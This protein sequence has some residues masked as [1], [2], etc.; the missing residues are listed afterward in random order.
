MVDLSEKNIA[1]GSLALC[2]LSLSV[3]FMSSN[4][5]GSILTIVFLVLAV[6][7]ALLAYAAFQAGYLVMPYITKFL[8]VT[9][10]V[11]GEY[12]I[13]PSQDVVVRNVG[14]LYQASVYLVAK[15]HE[16]ASVGGGEMESTAYM[17]LWERSLSTLKFPMAY[18]MIVFLEDI[19]KYREQVETERASAQIKLG[20][21]REKPRPDALVIDKWER[22]LAKQDEKLAKL[23]SGEKPMG[24]L[25]YVVTTGVGVNDAAAIAAAKKQANEIRSTVANALNV[26]IRSTSGEDLRKCFYFDHFLPPD[27]K[28]LVSMIG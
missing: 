13:P 19:V 6:L 17:D 9:E 23:T 20:K 26:D 1:L 28:D 5:I 10:I 27:P 21:E 11:A 25:T 3:V 22:E 24:L 15:V 14:G 4:V 2:V 18:N 12:K 16:A 7:G 8:G